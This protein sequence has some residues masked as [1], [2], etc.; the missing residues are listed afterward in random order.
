MAAI[1][2]VTSMRGT[3]IIATEMCVCERASLSLEKNYTIRQMCH[4][5]VISSVTR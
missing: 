2:R 3:Q 4:V 5:N 1:E